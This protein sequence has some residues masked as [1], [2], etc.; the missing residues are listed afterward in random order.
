METPGAGHSRVNSHEV[1]LL[2]QETQSEKH[3]PESWFPRRELSETA[4]TSFLGERGQK[5]NAGSRDVIRDSE[6]LAGDGEPTWGTQGNSCD[7]EEHQSHRDVGCCGE[8]SWG[9]VKKSIF[10]QGK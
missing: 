2:C 1:V 10:F 8:E 9:K 3:S 7:L 4:E 5:E 6:D